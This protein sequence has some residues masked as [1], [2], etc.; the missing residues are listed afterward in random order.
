[1]HRLWG[2]SFFWKCSKFKVNFKNAKKNWDTV[3]CFWDNSIWT[4]CVKLSLLSREYLSSAVN[5]LTK[6]LNILHSTNMDFLQL[7]Y[8][9]PDQQICLKFPS[10]RFQQC[11][12]PFTM[13]LV[14]GSSETGFFMDLSNHP[15][16]ES[17]I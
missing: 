15:F 14:Q 6:S 3:F 17:V 1:M 11:L 4:G 2:S 9:H 13:F 12:G 10:S 16:S 7:N 5:M 8:V